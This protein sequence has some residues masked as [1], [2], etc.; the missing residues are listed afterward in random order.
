M[1]ELHLRG[2]Q[3]FDPDLQERLFYHLLKRRG[4]E[5]YMADK[6]SRTEFGKRLAQKWA[7][8][9]ALSDTKGAHRNLQRRQFNYEGDKLN[10][11]LV[12]P[13]R[14]E[15]VLD[16]VYQAGG[17][18]R[19]GFNCWRLICHVRGRVVNYKKASDNQGRHKIYR[20][21]TLQKLFSGMCDVSSTVWTRPT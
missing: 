9:P 6:I 16:R 1:R 10:K 2:T 19:E 12:K 14:L 7:S 11:A 5:E 13:E 17:H 15:A 18:V 8:F 4:Y 21:I 3:I 20:Y